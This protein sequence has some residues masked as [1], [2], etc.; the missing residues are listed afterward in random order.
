MRKALLLVC[1]CFISFALLFL[2]STEAR[3]LLQRGPEK[4]PPCS[5]ERGRRYT[6][7]QLR[8]REK[9]VKFIDVLAL[10]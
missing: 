4:V 1:V 5:R 10:R 3:A 2:P 6:P 9:G 8:L 7:C